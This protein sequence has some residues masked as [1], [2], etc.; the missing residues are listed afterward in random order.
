MVIHPNIDIM[1]RILKVSALLAAIASVA[2]GN[3]V[4]VSTTSDTTSTVSCD[5]QCSNG[6]YCALID[7]TP[8][9]LAKKAQSGHLIEKCVCQPGFTGISCQTAV[10]QCILPERKCHNGV[11]C[12]QNADGEWGCDC[13][14]ADSLSAFAGYQCRNPSTEYCTGKYVPNAA[15]SF[16][17]NG[18]RCE[19]DFIAAQVAPGDT[20]FNQVYQ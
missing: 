9:E 18:G 14:V 2:S 20:A 10:E 12:T 3:N 13:S 19:G 6:G 8:E 5:L 15:L 1:T 17:T 11:P 7:G 16:C 4:G